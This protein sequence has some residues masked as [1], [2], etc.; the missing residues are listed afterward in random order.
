MPEKIKLDRIDH[1]C[2]IVDDIEKTLE[3][4]QQKFD[5]PK[6]K[7]EESTSTARLKGKVIGQ[8]KLK[9]LF[10]DITEN[11]SIEFL[12]IAEGNSV[13][14]DWLKKHGRTIHHIAVLS[15][16]LEN[17]AAKWE[18]IGVRV[19]QEDHGKWIYLDTE[20]ILGMNI[21]LVNP[22]ELLR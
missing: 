14:L 16:D 22:Q 9:A 7:I 11:M 6:C 12:E 13:E 3:R 5:V 4:I 19:L 17:E 20:E 15:E 1:V 21:E 2:V 18:K 10:V 8:Y